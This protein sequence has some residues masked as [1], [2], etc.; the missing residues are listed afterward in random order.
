MRLRIPA[1]L[2][3]ETFALLR[4]C[5]GGRR[6]CQVLWTSAWDDLTNISEV[7]HPHHLAHS[8]GFELASDW[9]NRFW[10]ELARTRRGIRVQVH[11]HPSE[12]FHS[13]TDDDHPII[14]T[15][16]FLSLVIPDFGL[17]PVGLNRAYLAEI[18]PNGKWQE[19]APDTRL[20][21]IR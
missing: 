12:A 17:G 11:S 5:G 9:I 14:H 21:I 4:R 2:L 7:V 18:D 16:G 6:E 8:G 19:V 10:Q 15:V 3:A 13:T 20:E 1:E